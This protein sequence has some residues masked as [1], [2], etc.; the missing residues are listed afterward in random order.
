MADIGICDNLHLL[1]VVF[2]IG[3][4][5]ICSWLSNFIPSRPPFDED[6]AILL[7][8]FALQSNL[9]LAAFF[10]KLN[11]HFQSFTRS[12]FYQD[13]IGI[14]VEKLHLI[15]WLNYLSRVKMD[16]S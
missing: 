6:N 2:V 5:I 7:S 11:L 3:I 13:M 4:F 15:S 16:W 9:C 1:P 10:F 12:V 14:F 8:G